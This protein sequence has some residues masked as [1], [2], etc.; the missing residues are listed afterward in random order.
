MR[1]LSTVLLCCAAALASA[2]SPD[3]APTF[4]TNGVRS[5][6]FPIGGEA[7]NCVPLADGKLLLA[8]AGYDGNANSYHAGFAI[9]DTVCGALDTTFGV[10]GVVEII[11]EQ[12]TVGQSAAVQPD[13]KI[14]GCGMIAPDNAGSQQW[15]GLFRL[16]A[17]GTVDSTFNGTGYV[18]FPFNGVGGFDGSAGDL[19]AVFVNPDSTI[20]CTGAAF[21]A[22]VGAFRFNHDGSPDTSYGVDGAARLQLPGFSYSGRGTGLLLADSSVLVVT[23]TWTGSDVVIA[24]AKF[25][26]FGEPDTTFGSNGLVV[27]SV[28]TYSA[29]MG[30]AVQSDGRILVSTSGAN[31][32]GFH[33]ARFMPN[34]D[35]DLSYG[36]NGVSAVPGNFG[37]SPLRGRK[38]QLLADGSTLQFGR[39]QGQ[40]P[41]ILKRD[42]NGNAISGFGTDGFLMTNI[43]DGNGYFIDGL[44]L[45]S[46]DVIAYGLTSPA[47]YLAIKLTYD[48]EANAL[49]VITANGDLLSTTGAG[50]FQWSFD[51]EDI[52]GATGSTYEPTQNGTYTVTMTVS[53]ECS[54]T[55]APYTLLNVGLS[56]VAGTPLR[57]LDNPVTDILAVRNDGAAVPYE[58]LSIA[59]QRI[60][61]GL[62]R[63]GRNDIGMTGLAGGVYLLRTTSNG[64]T[65]TQR[66]VKH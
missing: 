63:S 6:T 5:I 12:R 27:S 3:Y 37:G 34:G 64:G 62:L 43:N 13:G 8:G 22:L 54:Y 9:I 58:L 1:A 18:R 26:P 53:P 42:A 21:D 20:L 19:T 36:T 33:M 41:V 56:E 48:P 17:D 2:Q 40:N 61:D 55:S 7:L 16:K 45:P 30:M 35:L 51:G 11:H 46:G 29:E 4:G 32:E 38:M 10:N 47:Y 39:V 28:S 24:I 52:A 60:A 50:L 44:V 57:I 66:I 25:D 15:P 14:I 49:P 65:S 23:P 31:D 59:G